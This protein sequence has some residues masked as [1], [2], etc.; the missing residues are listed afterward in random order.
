MENTGDGHYTP[1]ALPGS[2]PRLFEVYTVVKKRHL[3]IGRYKPI[4][5]SRMRNQRLLLHWLEI[6]AEQC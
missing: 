4:S 6:E 2:T 3:G 5:Y 1:L